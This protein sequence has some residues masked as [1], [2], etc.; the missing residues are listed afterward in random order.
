M[1]ISDTQIRTLMRDKL[2]SIVGL[3]EENEWQGR[4]FTPQQ[5]TPYMR[6]TLLR[7]NETQTA[8]RELTA[9][10]IYQVDY[11]APMNSTLADSEGKAELIKKEFQPFQVLGGVVQIERA[12]LMA[13]RAEGGW[14]AYPVR[15]Y[16][17]VHATTNGG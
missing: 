2:T 9:L 3:P 15:I 13:G 8:N 16:F 14:H 11:F 17:R 10:G 12:E 6:E 5:G 7:N 1:S 4:T